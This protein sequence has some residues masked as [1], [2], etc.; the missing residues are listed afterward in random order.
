MKLSDQIAGLLVNLSAFINETGSRFAWKYIAL[1]LFVFFLFLLVIVIRLRKKIK[2]VKMQSE[3]ISNALA[4][5]QPGKGLERNLSVFLELVF[6]LVKADGFYFYLFDQKNNNYVLKVVRHNDTDN[7]QIGPSYSGLVPYEKENYTPPL[8]IPAQTPVKTSVIKDGKVPLLALPIK[9][10]AGIIR[11]GPVH[12]VPKRTM[13][14]LDY[15]CEKFQPVLDMV[16]EI[17]KMKNQIESI[18]ASGEAIRSL[19]KSALD[20][21]G[22]LS[23]IMVL[24]SKMVDAAGGCFLFKNDN[25]FEVAVVLGLEKEIEELFRQDQDAHHQLYKVVEDN[26]FFV[27][28][29]DMKEYFHIPSYLVASGMETLLLLRVFDRTI[30]GTAIFWYRKALPVEQHRFAAAQMLVKR[31]GDAMDR[32]LKFK[33]LSNSYLD[34]LKMLVNT[35]DNLEPYTVSHSE[36]VSRYAGII[37]R[38]MKMSDKDVKDIVLAGYLHD[39]GAL[40]LSGDI[41]FKVGK[42][43]DIEYETIKLHAEVGASI[44]EST[45]LDSDLASYIRHH[46]ER[47][48]G[49]GYPDGLKGEEIP[50]GARIIAVADVFNAKITGR[51]Y[52]EPASFERS[53]TDL[54]GA[55][56]TQLDPRVVEVLIDWFRKKQADPSRRGRSLGPCWEMRCCPPNILKSCPAY[57]TD[58]NCWEVG[59]NNCAAHGNSCPT[60]VVKTEFM[61]RTGKNMFGNRVV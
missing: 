15:L 40:G 24:S 61:H 10:G 51:K 32:Q 12:E 13:A 22:S 52:R 46:H 21:D 5:F 9:G 30:N 60:C 36:L 27:L 55:S 56:G 39:V 7:A 8:G 16:V 50:L 2:M 54:L 57:K 4:N 31:L 35:V 58:V 25:R 49:H 43:T 19:T 45:I 59:S 38:E 1:S 28:N 6:P 3:I 48:D 26:E 34:M 17:E 18:S 23:T 37:A 20:L 47:W 14:I 44:I 41:L 42:Y 53:L 11:I 29:R 33:E